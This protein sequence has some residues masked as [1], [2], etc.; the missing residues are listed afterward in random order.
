MQPISDAVSQGRDAYSRQA[1][2]AARSHLLAAEQETSLASEDLERLA[3][4]SHLTGLDADS[5][6]IFARAHRAFLGEG[7]AEGA[8]RCAFWLAVFSLLIQG[9]SARSSGWLARGQ[10]LLDDA[11]LDC[12]ERGYLLL[13]AALRCMFQG[14]VAAAYPTFEQARKIGERFQEA[15]LMALGLLGEGQSLLRLGRVPEGVALL[16]EVMVAVTAGGVSAVAVGIAYC[17]VIEDCQ[18]RFDLRRA[19]EWTEALDRWCAAQPDLVPYRRQCLVHRAEIMRLHGSWSEALAEAGRA[20]DLVSQIPDQRWTGGAFYQQAEVL[21]LR[22]RFAEAEA[23]YRQASLLGVTPQ[24]GLALLRLAQGRAE[25]ARTAIR[26]EVDEATETGLRARMLGACVEILLATGGVPEARVAANELSAI[27]AE[28]DVP[29]LN[30]IA[31]HALGA[32]LLAE[33]DARAALSALRRAW[34]A[35]YELEAPHEA[36]RVRV[37]IGRACRLLGDLDSADLELDAA[38]QIFQ[39]LGA[40]PDLERLKELTVPVGARQPGGLTGREAEVLRLIAAGKTNRQ[41]AAALVVSEKTVARH[42]SNI[43]AKLGLSSRSAATAYAY[44]H[45]LL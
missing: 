28:L 35:W 29:L 23:A 36:A 22:G 26:R 1:W 16:D 25:A 32:V 13:P 21:R 42:V 31:L 19:Q 45:G 20:R 14:E 24:P 43:F 39:Q 37:L 4:A 12:V 3:M 34:T 38:R 15:D 41:I 33:G 6:D 5:A 44:E 18:H 8:A 2:G 9:D 30:A 11:G 7:K 27:A 17:A 40:A 10:R